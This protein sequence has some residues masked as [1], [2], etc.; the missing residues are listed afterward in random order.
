MS[1]RMSSAAGEL[2]MDQF[3]CVSTGQGWR[4]YKLKASRILSGVVDDS[5]SSLSDHMIDADMG[6]ANAPLNALPNAPVNDA[7]SMARLRAKRSKKLFEWWVRHLLDT[8]LQDLLSAP[9]SATFQNDQATVAY[10]DNIF[11]R[12]A[13]RSDVKI[14]ERAWIDLNLLDEVGIGENSISLY[15]V[16]LAHDNALFPVPDRK[17]DDDLAEKVLESIMD[18]SGYMHESAAAEFNAA[19]GARRFEIAAGPNAGQRDY[20]ALVAHYAQAWQLAVKAG[21]IKVLPPQRA[22]KRAAATLA[23][24]V[25]EGGSAAAHMALEEARAM[26][27]TA[28][29]S[30]P[31]EWMSTLK[32]LTDVGGVEVGRGAQ[33]TTDWATMSWTS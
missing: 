12:A 6:G 20:M 28:G 2:D 11:D 23:D 33:T 13:R 15:A 27:S 18:C 16:R 26:R 30:V 9:G 5:G 7:R 31:Q 29:S 14:L 25:T 24:A 21:H 1:K 8:T 4:N 32:H 3:D 19:V 17:S 22:R 10:L